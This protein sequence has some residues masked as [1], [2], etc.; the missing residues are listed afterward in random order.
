MRL[1]Y[2]K[3]TQRLMDRIVIYCTNNSAY[4]R[5]LAQYFLFNFVETHKEA[6]DCISP[7]FLS[8]KESLG[9]ERLNL[10]MCER[11]DQIIT[12]Y[13]QFQENP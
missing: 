9:K 1:P 5:S 8:I 6:K 3:Y 13:T 7:V 11:F 12:F 4:F 10:I 2:S